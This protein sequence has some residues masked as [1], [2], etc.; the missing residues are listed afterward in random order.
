MRCGGQALR[1]APMIPASC[2]HALVS[3]PLLSVAGT[4]LDL[5]LTDRTWQR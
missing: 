5:L 1:V 3:S 2:V 4:C